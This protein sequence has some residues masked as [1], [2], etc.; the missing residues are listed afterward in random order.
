MKICM[1]S[2]SGQG[3]KS[4]SA[5]FMIT[6]AFYGTFCWDVTTQDLR[7]DGLLLF[8][9][10]SLVGAQWR[11]F[12]VVTVKSERKVQVCPIKSSSGCIHEAAVNNKVTIK[13]WTQDL[14]SGKWDECTFCLSQA[15]RAAGW[16][17]STP[18]LSFTKRLVWFCL[19]ISARHQE[20]LSKRADVHFQLFQRRGGKKHMQGR[21]GDEFWWSGSASSCLTDQHASAQL[22]LL[23]NHKKNTIDLDIKQASWLEPKIHLRSII[24]RGFG[25]WSYK[26]W[27]LYKI[28]LRNTRRMAI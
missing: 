25:G 4:P 11:G 7:G 14:N 13:V 22:S 23:L 8:P 15:A 21:C 27:P 19:A 9:Q 20:N 28:C 18:T 12:F 17:A 6:A 10:S 5:S 26:L 2:L 24:Q 3:C 1:K 16:R